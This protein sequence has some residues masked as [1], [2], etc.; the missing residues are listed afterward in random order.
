MKQGEG[1]SVIGRMRAFGYA[2]SGLIYVFKTQH[3]MW[4]HSLMAGVV[5][6]LGVNLH[7][8][9]SDWRWLVLA[10]TLVWSAEAMNTAVE[11]VCDT[12][13]TEH[14]P[15]IGKAKDVAAGAVL[16]AAIGAATI[17]ILVFWPHFF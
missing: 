16:A 17:G 6:A 7:I 11:L 12:I 8:A 1:F 4:F 14:H 2:I 15:L 5:V 9:A 10:I 3:A 13:T